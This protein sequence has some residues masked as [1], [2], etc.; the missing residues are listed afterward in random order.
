MCR[1][2]KIR[3]MTTTNRCAICLTLIDRTK[4][5]CDDRK[6][7]FAVLAMWDRVYNKVKDFAERD[8]LKI[9]T[10]TD[11]QHAKYF[12]EAM[13]ALLDTEN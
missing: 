7:R 8:G 3:T 6:C 5:V 13:D 4:E 2:T 10:I 11:R 1:Y 12:C 9:T